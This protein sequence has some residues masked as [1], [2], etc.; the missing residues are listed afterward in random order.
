M[1]HL[2]V[3]DL[4]LP[5]GIAV[6]FQSEIDRGWDGVV[7]FDGK[8]YLILA[9]EIDPVGGIATVRLSKLKARRVSRLD[10]DTP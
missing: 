10:L 4:D 7:D 2:K 1:G 5:A 8:P 6:A 3:A 9:I